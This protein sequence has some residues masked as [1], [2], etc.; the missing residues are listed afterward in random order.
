MKKSRVVTKFLKTAALVLPTTMMLVSCGKTAPIGSAEIDEAAKI[1]I[2]EVDWR[3]VTELSSQNPIRKSSRAVADVQFANGGRCTGFLVADN[4]LMTNNHCIKSARDVVGMKVFMKHETGRQKSDYAEISCTQYVGTNA[5]LDF[6][7][8]KCSGTPGQTYGKVE[9]DGS[10]ATAGDDV[11]VVH[12]N[13]DYYS[14]YDCDWSKKYSEGKVTEVTD[15]VS[16]NADTLG[17][18]SGSPIFSADSNKVIAI[19]NSG[20]GGNWMG[21][22]VKNMGVP[23]SRIVPY[24]EANFPGVLAASSTDTGSD[25]G[26]DTQVGDDNDT[27][28]KASSLAKNKTVRGLAIDSK[29]DV[30]IYA[31]SMKSGEVLDFSIFFSHAEGDLDFKVYKKVGSNYKFVKAKESSSDNESVR[32]RVSSNATYYVKVFGY[33]GAKAKYDLVFKKY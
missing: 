23:M 4:V 3:D 11:Y 22:G 15:M 20:Y 12:Q 33:R 2:G 27:Y 5:Q 8:V 31:V 19:H 17:G 10:G 7:L 14:D 21:R 26:D 16:H 18:S 24:I 1:I 29:E 6:S 28:A 30:D 13:C 9:L 32:M 25:Q